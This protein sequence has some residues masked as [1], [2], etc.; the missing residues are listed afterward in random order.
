[1]RGL[2]SIDSLLEALREE[3]EEELSRIKEELEADV[4][5]LRHASE[6]D[7]VILPD[8]D[9]RLE[10]A[11]REAA[12][13]SARQDWADRRA[14]L[15]DREAWIARIVAEGQTQ[16]AR[17]EEK[18]DRRDTLEGWIDE[19][20]ER[21]PGDTF[22]VVLSTDDA[23]LFEKAPRPVPSG[24]AARREI[25]MIADAN[26]PPGSCLART[27]EGRASFDNGFA[28]RS[29]RFESAWRA[30]LAEIYGS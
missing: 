6:I 25:R 21:L 2:G 28:A 5:R 30:A 23:A 10:S 18:A 26:A 12:E 24:T 9:A 27:P 8:R 4:A 1:V 14:A 11:R 15:E 7:P 13:D 3:V 16:F 22:E 20:V 17:G 19:A 29:R